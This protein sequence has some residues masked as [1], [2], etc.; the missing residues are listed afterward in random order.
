[1]KHLIEI[2]KI[3]TQKKV[4]RIDVFDA[5]YLNQKSNKFTIFYDALVARKLK[6]DREA[7]ALLYQSSPTDTRYRQLKSRFRRRLLNTLFFVDPDQP[8][9]SDYDRAYFSCSKDWALIS[10]LMSNQAVLAAEALARQTL[11]TALQFKFSDLI[12][13]CARVLRDFSAAAG[14]PSDFALFH[15]LIET[16]S[17][18]L[19]AEIRAE[20]LFLRCTNAIHAG[21]DFDPKESLQDLTDL[22]D[23]HDSL[24][25]KY[26]RYLAA[27]VLL[28][29]KA[30]FQAALDLCN[31]AERYIEGQTGFFPEDKLLRFYIHKMAAMLHLRDY[32]L[33]KAAVEKYLSAFSEGSESWFLFMEF[34]F[35]LAMHTAQYIQA[36]AIAE[37][38]TQH[39]RFKKYVLNHKEKWKIFE[40]YLAYVAQRQSQDFPAILQKGK[41][42]SSAQPFPEEA[43][44]YHK[45]HRHSTAVWLILKAL[46]LLEKNSLLKA[47][48]LIDQLR[49]FS[50]KYLKSEEDF[51]IVQFVRLLQQVAKANFQRNALKNAEKYLE[52][53]KIRTFQYSYPLS[54]QEVIPFEYL[55]EQVL[56]QLK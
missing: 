26:H 42:L 51:R 41:N 55:W 36:A 18:L 52:G 16:Y 9:V 12:V 13:N 50:G 4:K 28:E 5:S 8:G 35:L 48:E 23:R 56:E 25:I 39:P 43:L 3:L 30:E 38:T 14:K 37:K 54:C 33:G 6:N 24:L 7:A 21:E 20:A 2:A 22:A 34:Y 15:E 32:K 27:I 1:M 47:Q 45:D 29:A 46:L 11:Q 44:S 53:L 40:Y 10:I 49:D 17:A 31:E 19:Q